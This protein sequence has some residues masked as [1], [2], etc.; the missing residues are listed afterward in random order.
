M[1][2]MKFNLLIIIFTVII[3]GNLLAEPLIE[4]PQP[5]VEVFPDTSTWI[6]TRIGGTKAKQHTGSKVFITIEK[7]EKK[8]S[9]YTSC[10]FIRGQVTLKD[11]TI[12]FPELTFGKR[13]CDQATT[14]L[15]KQLLETLQQA[16]FWKIEEN[17]LFLFHKGE[18][19]LEFKNA[20]VNK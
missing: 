11:T 6:L 3:A 16:T 12:S 1:K 5:G 4:K 20:N 9:G 8:I 19:I 10:N 13:E 17:V 2:T 14:D 15:E 18:L 7:K